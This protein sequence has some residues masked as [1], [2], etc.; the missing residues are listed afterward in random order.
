M[1]TGRKGDKTMKRKA[2]FA[3]S[4]VLAL[5]SGEA[6]ATVT[7]FFSAGS[8][9]SSPITSANFTPGS[10]GGLLTVSLCVSTTTESVCGATI[11]LQAA[12]AA[13]SGRFKI[14]GRTLG[15]T[16]SDPNT[17]SVPFPVSI[18]NPK[19]VT[20]FGATVTSGTPP[21]AG[22]NQLLATFQL[23]PQST[24]T[25]SSYSISLA[26][27][28]SIASDN[29]NC[30]G[31]PVDTAISAS[32][33]LNKQGAVAAR[34]RNDFNGD[35]KRDVLIQNT[36]GALYVWH[37]DG[38][39]ISSGYLAIPTNGALPTPPAGWS[40]VGVAGDYNGDGKSD[41]L[42]QYTDGSLYAWMI[43][44][45]VISGGYLSIPTNGGL[46]SL[47]SGSGWSIA[48]VG[49]F[50]GDGKSDILLQ[51]TN[52][53]LYVWMVDGST[54]TGGYLSIPTTG[55]LPGLG[56]GSGWSVAT[57][58]DFNGDG[59]ADILLQNTNGSLYMWMID[60]SVISGG[61]VSIPS[62]G[63]LP[64]LG[65]GSGWTIAG[66]G[67]FNGDGKADLL[68]QNTN[69]SLYVWMIDGSVISGGYVSIPSNG[70]LP[71]LGAGSGWSIGA[72]GD[73][74]GDGKADILLQNTNG[75]LY[76]WLIDG[77]VI[78]GGFVSIPANGAL[79]GL[80]GGWSNK[81]M[82]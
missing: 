26:S 64:S 56:A 15:A 67:D 61:Y 50:N 43:D 6:H 2:F 44:G 22:P 9:C 47:G 78:S 63:G 11:Q 35:G 16:L 3:T 73:F 80:S 82:R 1:Q 31:S 5:I 42:L 51:N 24:A 39:T 17:T 37:V 29:A 18:T 27:L 81:V 62:N 23:E 32:L 55:G 38:A 75:A 25:N 33:T 20:D 69:G 30:F 53:S 19:Q 41:V 66:A 52:G 34:V 57:V 71:S 28:S 48:A 45:S 7:P 40:V 14:N 74:N 49:D 10:P 72:I 13:E 58:A 46:P 8:T 59:K 21:A 54:I 12:S 68:L 70:Q 76:A 4:F 77:A 60:G 79:P 36:S 65:A